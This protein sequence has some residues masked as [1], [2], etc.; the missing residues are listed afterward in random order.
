MNIFLA[1]YCLDPQSRLSVSDAGEVVPQRRE[2][3]VF[4][5]LHVRVL[6]QFFHQD[7]Y[8][9]MVRRE[10]IANACNQALQ[11]QRGGASLLDREMVTTQIVANWFANRRKEQKKRE[12]IVI[13]LILHVLFLVPSYFVV[14]QQ[15]FL[16]LAKMISFEIK[17]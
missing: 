15:K 4:R 16:L 6:E 5:P 3:F 12:G 14:N 13:L 17:K 7:A 8:P 2:R 1:Q 9:D 11:L 10:E